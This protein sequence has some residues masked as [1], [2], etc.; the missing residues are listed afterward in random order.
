MTVLY[1]RTAGYIRLLRELGVTVVT[2]VVYYKSPNCS[3]RP[4]LGKAPEIQRFFQR[5]LLISSDPIR[6]LEAEM[7]AFL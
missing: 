3:L 4:P 1:A 7:L 5:L 2:V 6:A